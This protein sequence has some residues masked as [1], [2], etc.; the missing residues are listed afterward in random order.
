MALT[1]KFGLS[2]SGSPAISRS[3]LHPAVRNMGSMEAINGSPMIARTISRGIKSRSPIMKA[4]MVR[5]A[6]EKEA[7]NGKLPAL[8]H[9]F[10]WR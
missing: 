7:T 5:A 6:N 4:A 2:N 8:Q 10:P 3:A 9:P 1:E